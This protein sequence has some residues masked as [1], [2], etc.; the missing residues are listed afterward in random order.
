MSLAD[1]QRDAAALIRACLDG[2]DEA[3]AVI[4][5]NGDTRD[6]AVQTARLAA[7]ALTMWL[8]D[9][10]QAADCIA[11]AQRHLAEDEAES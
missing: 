10:D 11:W 5:D 6:V 1:A 2:D 8:G 7:F 3:A 4:L 9:S